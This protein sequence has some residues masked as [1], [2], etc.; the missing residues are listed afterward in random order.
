MRIDFGYL[1]E[2]T[3][4]VS[5]ILGV[6]PLHS[7]DNSNRF[8]SKNVAVFTIFFVAFVLSTMK[9]LYDC[10]TMVEYSESIYQVTSMVVAFLFNSIIV[11]KTSN[12]FNLFNNL[13]CYIEKREFC[14][15]YSSIVLFK[16]QTT[17]VYNSRCNGSNQTTHL[18]RCKRNHW[19]MVQ[20]NI[21]GC[22]QIYTNI[23]NNFEHMCYDCDLFQTRSNRWRLRFALSVLVS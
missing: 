11:W 12:I 15:L 18:R 14:E 1:H 3:S 16:T 20:I 6:Y 5:Q 17:T 9:L 23:S 7:V 2:S 22:F 19:K 21:F 10:T 4:N 8:T 13:D